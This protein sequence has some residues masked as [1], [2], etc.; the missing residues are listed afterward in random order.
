MKGDSD[1]AIE[2]V[3]LTKVFGKTRAVDGV[4]LRVSKGAPWVSTLR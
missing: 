4:N 3:E 1:Y 2:T